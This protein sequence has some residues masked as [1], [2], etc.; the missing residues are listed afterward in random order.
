MWGGGGC[1]Q[2]YCS[3]VRGRGMFGVTVAVCGGEGV[4]GVTVAVCR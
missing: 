1:V 2:G 3:S 4:F